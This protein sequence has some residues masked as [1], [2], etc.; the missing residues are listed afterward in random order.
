MRRE[1]VSAIGE[2]E[3]AYSEFGQKVDE[4]LGVGWEVSPGTF[5]VSD[6]GDGTAV[7]FVQVEKPDRG[8]EMIQA[9]FL[10]EGPPLFLAR[11]EQEK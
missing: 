1:F 9:M 7:Y 3:A 11:W 2:S 5:C 6:I 8:N 10:S 4:R